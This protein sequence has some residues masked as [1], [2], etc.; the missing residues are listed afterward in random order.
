MAGTIA[1][2]IPARTVGIFGFHLKFS[3]GLANLVLVVE[4]IAIVA[5]GVTAGVQARRG[6]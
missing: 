5:L 6:S 3:S 4:A 1:G 2:F